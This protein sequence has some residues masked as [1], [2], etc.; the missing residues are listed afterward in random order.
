MKPCNNTHVFN[1]SDVGRPTYLLIVQI[2]IVH[3]GGSSYKDVHTPWGI[4]HF[5]QGSI[6]SICL[7]FPKLSN[8]TKQKRRLKKAFNIR[9]LEGFN[10]TRED[11]FHLDRVARIISK[12]ILNRLGDHIQGQDR[13]FRSRTHGSYLEWTALKFL[14]HG[15]EHVDLT[16]LASKLL[17]HHVIKHFLGIVNERQIVAHHVGLADL[18]AA[19]AAAGRS[20]IRSIRGRRRFAS[21]FTL[22]VEKAT[23]YLV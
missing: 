22:A 20:S 9:L 3:T 1:S 12:M 10:F 6:G 19:N 15:L 16:R 13:G 21:L 18:V 4:G 8:V 17:H 5:C 23:K 11:V 7:I 14:H 2:G